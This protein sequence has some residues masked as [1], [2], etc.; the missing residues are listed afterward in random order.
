MNPLP[1]ERPIRRLGAPDGAL[2][3]RRAAAR[4]KTLMPENERI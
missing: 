2:P 4:R 3:A 1:D